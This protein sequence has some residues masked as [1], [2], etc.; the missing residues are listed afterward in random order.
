MGAYGNLMWQLLV[1]FLL[2]F[3]LVVAV[4]GV[5]VGV[6]LIVSSQK[7]AQLFHGLNRWVS[8]RH[9]LKS[10][11]MPRE[12]DRLAR[13]YHRW[14]AGG[15]VLGG[16][17]AIFGLAAGVDANA[18]SVAFAE[19]RFVPVVTIAF[20]SAKWFLIA[21][22]AFGVVIGGM[23]LF[24][25]NAESTLERFANQWVSSRRV[26]RSWDDMNMT[27][28]TLVE[29]HPRPAGWIIVCTSVAAVI[30][31]IVMLVRYH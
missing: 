8:T 11:E 4:A 9:A 24:Y 5:A 13:N 25:P 2:V 16:L 18:L 26:T 17:I 14:V 27:L 3:F 23:L 20:N 10:L 19:K 21:G 30:C 28:D 15:F 29:A 31:A 1:P 12:T 22:S 7:T 6:G